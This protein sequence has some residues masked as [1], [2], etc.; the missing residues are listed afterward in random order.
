MLYA[1]LN[2]LKKSLSTQSYVK[3]NKCVVIILIKVTI[4]FLMLIHVKKIEFSNKCITIAF[5]QC[6]SAGLAKN[7]K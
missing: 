5:H 2:D 6:P 4:Q 1:V 3:F 7:R